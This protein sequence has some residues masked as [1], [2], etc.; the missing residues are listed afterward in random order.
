M[1]NPFAN[2]LWFSRPPPPPKKKKKKKTTFEKNVRKGENAENA[3]NQH[4]LLFP[5]CFLPFPE[6]EIVILSHIKFVVGK[7]FQ[8]G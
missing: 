5:Q 2:N 3:G 7:C 8:F 6:T 1:F 4:F